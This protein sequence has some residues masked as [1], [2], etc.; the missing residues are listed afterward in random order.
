M[1]DFYTR[2]GLPA[3]E[4]VDF[5]AP[6]GTPVLACA[7]G[8]VTRIER[9]PLA[10]PASGWP[11]GIQVRIEHRDQHDIYE[12]IYAHLAS[13]EG[14]LK[15]GDQIGRRQPIGLS[16]A[17]GNARGDHLHLTLKRRGSSARGEKQ[18]LGNGTYVTYPSD[19]IDPTPYFKE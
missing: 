4:G 16:D 13:V 17:T 7:D 3:H 14:T 19:I 2:F 15:V 10:A 9:V 18:R 8:T 6:H 12:T 11:Y 5:H 1:A